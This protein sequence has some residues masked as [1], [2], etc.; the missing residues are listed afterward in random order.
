MS[1]IHGKHMAFDE[2]ERAVAGPNISM[3]P[4]GGKGTSSASALN[5]IL[6]NFYFCL[7]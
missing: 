4:T 3:K 7:M 1:D 6:R 5:L 2:K